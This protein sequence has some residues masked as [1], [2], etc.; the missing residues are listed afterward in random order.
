MPDTI[1]IEGSTFETDGGIDHFR[2]GLRLRFGN[3]RGVFITLTRTHYQ[4]CAT[5]D[6]C[7][8]ENTFF[9]HCFWF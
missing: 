4:D 3:N 7:K 5:S 1:G 9:H 2:L 6:G 8:S